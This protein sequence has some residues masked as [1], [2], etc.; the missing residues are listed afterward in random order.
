VRFPIPEKAAYVKFNQ[1]ASR[2][3]LT[4][5][6]VA[7]FAD[8]VRVAVTGASNDGV[9]RWTEAEK[10][11]SADFSAGAIAGL[12]VDASDMISDLHGTPAYRANLVKVLTGRAVTAA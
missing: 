11:L 4:A 1:P 5:V 8:G 7:K 6:F 10:A 12:T 9:F 2:F 3:A